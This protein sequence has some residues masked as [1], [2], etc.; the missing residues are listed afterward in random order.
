MERRRGA[1]CAAPRWLARPPGVQTRQSA[2]LYAEKALRQLRTRLRGEAAQLR[3]QARTGCAGRTGTYSVDFRRRTG[4]CERNGRLFRSE[5]TDRRQRHRR[6][7]GSAVGRKS[8]RESQAWRS[9]G[10]NCTRPFPRRRSSR[11]PL[12]TRVSPVRARTQPPRLAA[13]DPATRGVTGSTVAPRGPRR[14]IATL[15]FCRACCQCGA[16]RNQHWPPGIMGSGRRDAPALR[17]SPPCLL[18]PRP[19]APRLSCSGTTRAKNASHAPRCISARGTG[20]AN[21]G[22]RVKAECSFRASP[23][24]AAAGM[25]VHAGWCG[26]CTAVVPTMKKISWEQIE[27]RRSAAAQ[28]PRPNGAPPRD[29]PRS[30][31]AAQQ[32]R[33]PPTPRHASCRFPY[34]RFSCSALT[35][36]PSSRAAAPRCSLSW[37]TA[38]PSSPSPSTRT[39]PRSRPFTLHSR[40]HTRS[41]DAARART[42][43]LWARRASVFAGSCSR[44][45]GQFP[46]PSRRASASA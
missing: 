31:A 13:F 35:S 16:L 20:R 41:S 42:R 38:T 33:P 7:A 43:S 37:P 15:A 8:R 36:R 45:R 18:F 40:P 9:R 1:P 30:R 19:L 17:L 10:K 2:L 34:S 39:A 21:T 28:R 22:P 6:V 3:K 4:R 5:P 46:H 14:P 23:R 32:R 12:T 25:E 27:E 11:K 44:R 24:D 26:P 29:P